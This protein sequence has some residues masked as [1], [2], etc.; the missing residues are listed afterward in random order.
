MNLPD[1]S[2]LKEDQDNYTV[3]H[4]KGKSIS[5]P[6]KGLSSKAQEL[7]GKLK[8]HQ[9][10]ADGGD[11]EAPEAPQDQTPQADFDPANLP[12]SSSMSQMAPDQAQPEA[13]P[14]APGP[15]ISGNAEIAATPEAPQM[16]MSAPSA[17]APNLQGPLNEAKSNL[18]SSLAQQQQIS[19]KEAKDI[20]EASEDLQQLP[21]ANE[22]NEAGKAQ[23]AAFQKHFSDL[24]PIDQN[25]VWNNKSVPAKIAASIG[26]VLSGIGSGL[27]GQS[28]MAMDMIHKQIQNDIESQKNEQGKAMNLWQMNRQAMGN[29]QLANMRTEN[30][31]LSAVKVKSMQAAAQMQSP[32]AQQRMTPVILGI[33]QQMA[34]NNWMMS[35]LQGAPSGTEMQHVNEMNVM[36]QM[37][38]E[39]Y[40]DM[41][42]KYIPGVGVAR[43]PVTEADRTRLRTLDTLNNVTDKALHFANTVGTTLPLTENNATANSLRQQLVIGFQSLHDLKRLSDIDLKYNMDNL[44]SPG[45]IMTKNALAYFNGL[46]D[47]INSKMKVEHTQLG[48]TPFQKSPQDMQAQ[49]WAK[50]NPNDPRAQRILQMTGGNR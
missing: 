27:T 39:L 34:Q 19:Q 9:G 5:V 37:R 7:I 3:G 10:F 26:L 28:N 20:G 11:V 41:A 29:D 40:K 21:T 17:I 49:A 33:E 6:K 43:T 36:Q 46:K 31:L 16:P 42:S 35:R 24:P 15:M 38:P 14:Q 22:I 44:P 32:L 13:M 8:K 23:D 2:L 47:S 18:E 4:P 25:R 1:F 30:Q 12:N 48:I 45:T 50:A